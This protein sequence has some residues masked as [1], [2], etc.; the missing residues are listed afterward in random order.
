MVPVVGLEPTR[1]RYQWILSFKRYGVYDRIARLC[2]ELNRHQKVSIFKPFE[3]NFR[4][5]P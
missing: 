5:N 3:T 2:K 4:E 1:Y